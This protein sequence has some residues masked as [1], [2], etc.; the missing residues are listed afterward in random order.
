M[1]HKQKVALYWVI[2]IIAVVGLIGG[3]TYYSS[4]PGPLDAFAQCLDEEGASFYGAYWCPAC[5]EQKRLFG[6][7]EQYLP[8]VECSNSD[9]SQNQ[10]CQDAGIQGYPTWDFADGTRTVGVLTPQELAD[11]TACELPQ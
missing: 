8:Y 7:S 3:L 10:L 11:V 2:G 1:K 5:N 9:R 4:A 6:R